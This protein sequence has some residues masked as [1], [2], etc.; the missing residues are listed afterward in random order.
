MN[1][2]SQ[3]QSKEYTSDLHRVCDLH[4]DD[5]WEPVFVV[6]TAGSAP[7]AL[8]LEVAGARPRPVHQHAPAPA[9]ELLAVV[10]ILAARPGAQ[11]P[12]AQD[13]EGDVL[14]GP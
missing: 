13:V 12:G 7:V 8:P 1:R 4:Q 14:A 2:Q 9:P 3:R 11:L 5:A 10:V 6:S